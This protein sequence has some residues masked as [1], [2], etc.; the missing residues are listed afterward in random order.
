MNNLRSFLFVVVLLM[1]PVL[2]AQG[3]SSNAPGQTKKG[4]ASQV[5]PVKPQNSSERAKALAD[6]RK[7][8]RLNSFTKAAVGSDLSSIQI[9]ENRRS[10]ALAYKNA[11]AEA[12]KLINSIDSSPAQA[13][14]QRTSLSVEDRAI[15]NEV[16]KIEFSS[17]LR[18]SQSGATEV[19]PRAM[20]L[21]KDIQEDESVSA[22]DR[23][24]VA[25]MALQ[26]ESA[27]ARYLSFEARM[28]LEQQNVERLYAAFPQEPRVWESMV[29]L[30]RSASPEK[31]RELARKITHLPVPA[32]IKE[33]A[34]HII[35]AQDMIGEPFQVM[36]QDESGK[37][38]DSAEFIGKPVVFYVWSA[39]GQANGRSHGLVKEAVS[40]GVVL[41]SVN[42]DKDPVKA[43]RR[44]RAAPQATS[45]YFDGRGLKG[46]LPRQLKSPQIPS[47]H[48]IDANGHYVGHGQPSALTTLLS[49]S[50]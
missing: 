2:I 11:A 3:N 9:E 25:A 24:L 18:A 42:I 29:V 44:G 6:L 5:D 20:K 35:E 32:T 8:F 37:V 48:V 46:P 4:E 7:L 39:T 47:V 16:K 43:K 28:E 49:G 10:R 27:K 26:A 33:Q 31:G 22:S 15:L 1:P 17:L 14:G 36:W 12:R 13:R 40:E 34:R 41:V 45:S 21:A 23:Y 19:E 30:A 38:R 50:K